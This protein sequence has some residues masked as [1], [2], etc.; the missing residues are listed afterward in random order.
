MGIFN[1]SFIDQVIL[2]H[3]LSKKNSYRMECD[4]WPMSIFI[5]KRKQRWW[6]VQDGVYYKVSK[7]FLHDFLLNKDMWMAETILLE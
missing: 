5:F 1:F 2:V 3:E 6:H 4:K 7:R